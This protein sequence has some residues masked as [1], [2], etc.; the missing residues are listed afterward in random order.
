V[1]VQL[2]TSEVF[3]SPGDAIV[4]QRMKRWRHCDKCYVV[5]VIWEW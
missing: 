2:S 4:D 1:A 3:A 5:L